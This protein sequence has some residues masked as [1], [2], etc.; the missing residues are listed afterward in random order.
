MKAK[1]LFLA[2]HVHI[3]RWK[4]QEKSPNDFGALE[5]F[6]PESAGFKNNSGLLFLLLIFK[7]KIPL[8]CVTIKLI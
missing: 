7:L 5:W 8:F 4:A 1:D 3:I 2:M 6:S